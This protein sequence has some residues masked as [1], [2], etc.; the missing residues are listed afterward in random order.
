MAVDHI[1]DNLRRSV[2]GMRDLSQL[3][4]V[5]GGY[6]EQLFPGL[7]RA[8]LSARGLG[9]GADRAY[10]IVH[11]PLTELGALVQNL[12]SAEACCK[13]LSILDSSLLYGGLYRYK[14]VR[15]CRCLCLSRC[16]DA[17]A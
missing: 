16:L 9:E 2:P 11:D 10:W 1:V 6:V 13:T 14:C 5:A 8:F 17:Y 4:A 7:A 15:R 12:E 3:P